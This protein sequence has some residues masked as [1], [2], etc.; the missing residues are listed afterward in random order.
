MSTQLFLLLLLGAVI[1]VYAGLALTTYVRM[2]GKRVVICPE[3]RQPAAVTVDAA[4]AALSAVRETPDIRLKTCSRWPE[5]EDCNQDCTPQIAIAPE[6][7]LAINMLK[8]WYEGRVCAVCQR[9]I[10][11]VHAGAPKPGLLNVASPAREILSWEEIPAEQLPA[12][13]ESH[14]PV[15]S[16]CYMAETFRR[17]FAD[18]VTDRAATDKRDLAVH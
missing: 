14:L 10:P 4:H 13:L 7:T 17:Q 6:D 11:P 16:N 12:V 9:E 18:R 3:T 5:R 8:H 15:C 2:R 1:L